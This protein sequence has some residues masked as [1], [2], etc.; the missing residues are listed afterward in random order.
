MCPDCALDID[1]TQEADEYVD[2]WICGAKELKWVPGSQEVT[3]YI[4][5]P[6]PL[7]QAPSPLLNPHS[8][9]PPM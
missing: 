7:P 1:G 5:N 4:L 9:Y 3:S 6:P 8:T 2:K